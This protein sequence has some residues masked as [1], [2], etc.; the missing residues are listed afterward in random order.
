MMTSKRLFRMSVLKS[1]FQLFYKL[2]FTFNGCVISFRVSVKVRVRVGV[3]V[4]EKK[5]LENIIG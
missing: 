5:M 4:R 3:R 1:L 2:I